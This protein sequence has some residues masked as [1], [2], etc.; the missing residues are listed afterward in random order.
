M[1]VRGASCLLRGV[2]AAD[3]WHAVTAIRSHPWALL[4]FVVLV[5][6]A[7]N[8]CNCQWPFVLCVCVCVSYETRLPHRLR[9]SLPSSASFSH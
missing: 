3:L 8:C 6:G 5:V 9:V 2:A 4:A 1:L 7:E